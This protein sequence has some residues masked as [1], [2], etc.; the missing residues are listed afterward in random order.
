MFLEEILG[1]PHDS[2]G[3]LLHGKQIVCLRRHCCVVRWFY[4]PVGKVKGF[5]LCL[6]EAWLVGR[7]LDSLTLRTEPDCNL[8]WRNEVRRMGP[9]PT[10][11][12]GL[13]TSAAFQPRVL[14]G[15]DLMPTGAF[16]KGEERPWAAD[17]LS[18]S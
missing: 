11:P 17:P 1:V 10:V 4:D 14:G 16:F 15:G 5:E 2:D 9:V 12:E 8:T 6:G 13:L 3:C 18:L 7:V